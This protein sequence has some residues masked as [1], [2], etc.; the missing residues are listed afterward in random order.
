M[1]T[2]RDSKVTIDPESVAE[3]TNPIWGDLEA[4]TARAIT[5]KIGT[6]TGNK[7]QLTAEG[8]SES[9]GYGDRSGIRT[10]SISYHVERATLDAAE[11]AT[12]A[13]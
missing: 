11:S 13:L 5:G 6:Q 12:L 8:V 1:I 3:S 4:A 7:F 10:Q 2:D 9:V